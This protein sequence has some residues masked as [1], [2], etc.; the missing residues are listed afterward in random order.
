MKN[1]IL[2]LNNL[3]KKIT[4]LKKKNKKIILCHGVFDLLHL[5][6][7]KHF[8]EAKKYGDIIVVTITPN[9]YV[10][11][12]PNRPVFN[13]N[14]RMEAIASLET[15]D[16]V[17]ENKWRDAVETIKLLKP[18]VYCKGPDY[19][20][21]QDDITKRIYE[22]NKAVKKIKGIIKYTNDIT[23]SSSNILNSNIDIF[24]QVQKK[25]IFKIK[26]KTNFKNIKQNLEKLKK[27]KVLVVGETIIDQY[28]FCEALGKSGKDPVM[29][30]HHKKTEQ[31]LGGAAAIANNISSFCDSVS[32][33]SMIGSKLDNINF[34][35]K[36]LEKN[37]KFKY[38]EKK[39]SPTIIKKKFIDLISNNKLFGVYEIED[40]N[41]NEKDE[42]KLNN[43]LSKN[44][45]KFDLIVLSD[46]GHGFITEKIAKKICNKSRFLV[47][48]SQLNAANYGH[49]NIKKFNKSNCIII[50][51]SELRHE[52][53]DKSQKL[54]TL[55][56]K[57][58]KNL[59]AKFMV[60]TRGSEGVLLYDK[61]LKKFT[62]CPAFAN[63]IVDKIGAG[64]SLMS[65]L[66]P[67]LKI[68]LDKEVLLF[69]SSLAGAQSVESMGNSKKIDKTQI[70]KSAQYI[71]K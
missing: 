55:I 33:Y 3:S 41:L 6:H 21:N 47:L 53:R 40:E 51:E 13:T 59:K 42:N 54:E 22:E 63:N 26:S 70:L 27:L 67:L 66:A 71:L 20:K 46:Y 1:K 30:F 49:H 19:K 23:F 50:N 69:L 17:S 18:N 24:N 14:Q 31:Y 11:K 7:I 45:S 39:N 15:V 37:V 34:I 35:K 57:M 2:S 62:S 12:G 10:S 36:N 68:N 52:L 58:A 48:N 43:L 9:K 65:L 44:L 25:I 4:D 56:P 38:I 8:E 32:L 61:Y 28:I 5:G 29:M 60:V 16:Y 64:D